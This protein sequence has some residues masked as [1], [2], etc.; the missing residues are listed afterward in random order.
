MASVRIVLREDK[1]RKSGEAPL[2]LRLTH[3]CKSKYK[4]LRVTVRPEHWQADRQR[5]NKSHPYSQRLNALL[6]Q[7]RADLEQ[8]ALSLDEDRT[9]LG[10]KRLR[11]LMAGSGGESYLDYAFGLVK[12]L[13]DQGRYSTARAYRNTYEQFESWLQNQ[14]SRKDLA[15]IDFTSRLGYDYKAYLESELRNKAN[16]VQTKFAALRRAMN[17]AHREGLITD[18]QNVL[19]FISTPG[20][21]TQKVIPSRE[22]IERIE[23]LELEPESSL[24]HTRNLYLFSSRMAGIRFS[25]AIRLRWPQL[26]GDHLSWQTKKT[27]RQIRLLVPDSVKGILDRYREDKQESGGFIFPFLRGFESADKLT[28]QKRTASLN[29]RCNVDLKE[30]AQMAD[31]P[32]SYSFHTSRHFFATESLRRG[33]RVEVLKEIMTHSSI[34]QTMAYVRIS[35]ADMDLA[36]AG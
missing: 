2:Y 27:G 21:K 17:L 35:N 36:M 20:R 25:D 3:N 29:T 16:T 8:F 12:N 10:S 1:I 23:D 22:E 24:W 34:E 30:L 13:A 14:K 33:V 15:F 6:A 4:A 18:A 32:R 19:R 31:L 9:T 26:Q 7:K 5:V 11:G 28:L